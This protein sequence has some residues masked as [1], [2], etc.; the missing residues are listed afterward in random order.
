VRSKTLPS[1]LLPAA[2]CIVPSAFMAGKLLY[3][4][5]WLALALGFVLLASQPTPDAREMTDAGA[6]DRR[7]ALWIYLGMILPQV[8]ASCDYAFL[9]RD[10]QSFTDAWLIAG[11]IVGAASMWFR[12]AAIRTLGRF[13]TATVTVQQGQRVID[14]GP[15]RLIRHPSYT[16]ALGT[17]LGCALVFHSAIGAALVAAVA[18]PAY[19]YR[20]SVEER[21]L[22]QELGEPYEAYMRRT[23]RLLPFV[24]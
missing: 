19:L 14:T 24:Y 5:P 10:R 8:T 23:K 4:S 18:V 11:T 7:S 16:G 2:V 22:A 6:A 3:P 20:M 13:F 21:R 12:V 17:A 15:Y 1:L 9:Q